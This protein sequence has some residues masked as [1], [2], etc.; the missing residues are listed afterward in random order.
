MRENHPMGGN[1]TKTLLH[2]HRFR[3]DVVGAVFG[4]HFFEIFFQIFPCL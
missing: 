4:A 1:S 3:E 2:N